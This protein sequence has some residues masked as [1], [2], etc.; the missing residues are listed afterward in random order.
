VSIAALTSNGIEL[1]LSPSYFG[2][3]RESSVSVFADGSARDRFAEDGYLMLRNAVTADTV[4]RLREAYFRLFDAR[5]LKDGD[6][7]R[8]EF[9]GCLPPNL[10]PH[11][12]A[13]H[14][15]HTFVRTQEFLA[16]RQ[17]PLFRAMAE[18]LLGSAAKA[19]WRTPLRHFVRGSKVSSRAH[20]D[21]TYLDCSVDSCVTIW[22]PLGDCALRAGGLLYL[23]NS[24]QNSAIEA[25]C[26]GIG[27]MDR[28]DD[29]RPLTHDLKWLAQATGLRWLGTDCRAGDVILH[30]PTIVHASTDPQIDCMRV[31]TD[32]R[33][34]RADAHDDP[35][36]QRDW[37][38]DDGY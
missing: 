28:A 7:R 14:P 38:A 25:M 22:V 9:S 16:F 13:G 11:G 31:S 18:T 17:L 37:A 8:G 3:L 10:P 23:E 19:V 24:H 35:R 30:S 34:L 20:M 12:V 36:W 15:A 2:P 1:P 21:R 26:R 6:A 33:F 5:L 27:P 4:L 29:R 32:I